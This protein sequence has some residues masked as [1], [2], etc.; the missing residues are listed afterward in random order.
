[1][2]YQ[3]DERRSDLFINTRYYESYGSWRNESY[4]DELSIIKI[5]L[6]RNKLF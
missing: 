3:L 2:L 5:S 1:M 6:E 4:D